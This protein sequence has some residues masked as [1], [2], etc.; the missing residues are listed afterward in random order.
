MDE[1]VN[2]RITFFFSQRLFVKAMRQ[3]KR[4][5][6]VRQSPIYSH[7]DESVVG[8][9]SIRAYRRQGEFIAKCDRLI[10][11]SQRPYFLV[12]TGYRYVYSSNILMNYFHV[13]SCLIV[14][15]HQ[16]KRNIS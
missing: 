11:E 12:L 2:A 6:S 4:I 16:R 13:N 9:T 7:F 3:W 8:S 10:D 1:S 14:F 5:N 15:N